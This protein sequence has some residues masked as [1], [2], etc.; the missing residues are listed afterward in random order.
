MHIFYILGKH[1]KHPVARSCFLSQ[2]QRGNK[3]AC[4]THGA[5]R[6]AGEQLGEQRFFRG[7]QRWLIDW[8]QRNWNQSWT[9]NHKLIIFGP[10]WYFL[11]QMSSWPCF[12]SDRPPFQ[13]VVGIWGVAV[14]TANTECQDQLYQGTWCLTSR[15]YG[16]ILE[17]LATILEMSS[18]LWLW[19]V[20]AV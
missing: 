2:I 12:L 6:N 8:N 7:A 10:N 13:Q 18:C 4:T 15:A 19:I 20:L 11:R 9:R 14:V 3:Y 1:K 16:H 5:R 17:S